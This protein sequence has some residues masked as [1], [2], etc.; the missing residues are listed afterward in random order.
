TTL[1]EPAFAVVVSW[2]P[3]GRDRAL[4]TVTLAAGF[5][6][7]IFMPIEA[8][9]L[10]RVGWRAAL[11]ILAVVLAAITIPI[12]ALVLRRGRT[13]RTVAPDGRHAAVSGLSLAEAARTL[14]FWV[15]AV[16]F[17]I[18]NFATAA[19]SVHLIPYLV[20]HGYSAAVAAAIVGWMG[21]V[22]VPGR[23]LF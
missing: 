2:F 19:V 17:F 21:A 8:W 5:A 10:T 6:S 11:T 12:H 9:L 3:E 7:T 16:A 18:G 1:Y 13:T 22:Q 23:L 20:D 15:L 14:V 4:L